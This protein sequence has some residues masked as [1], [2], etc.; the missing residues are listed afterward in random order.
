M[1][2]GFIDQGVVAGRIRHA[3]IDM[4]AIAHGI[5]KRPSHERD[6]D[7]V[8]TRDLARQLAEEKCSVSSGECFL[9]TKRNLYL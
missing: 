2:R 8:L 1:G 9:V 3:Q 5:S 7:V 6:I 4:H